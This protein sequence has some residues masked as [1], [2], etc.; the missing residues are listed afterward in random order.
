MALDLGE[1][2]AKMRV[3]R[4]GLASG[5]DAGRWEIKAAANSISDDVEDGLGK[6]GERGSNRMV[7]AITGGIGSLGPAMMPMLMT[8]GAAGG[9][10]LATALVASLVLAVPI[11]LAGGVLAAG[12]MAAAKD[13]AVG[14]AFAPLKTQ[15][16]AALAK[17][18]EPFKGPLIRAATT[19]SNAL[20]QITP[21]LTQMGTAVA[22]LVDQLA[23]MLAQMAVSIMPGLVK[24]VQA[25]VP[26]LA[27]LIRMLP[28]LGAAIGSV[29]SGIAAAVPWALRF[30]GAV[31]MIGAWIGSKLIPPLKSLAGTWLQAARAA[32]G[33]V[34]SA[35]QSNRPQ[36]Q[37][38][39]HWVS[40]IVSWV[41]AHLV[42]VLKSQ[43]VGSLRAAG[44][45]ISI[46]IR[47]I[48]LFVTAIQK[49]VGATKTTVNA[50]KS[51]VSGI[52]SFWA[53]LPGQIMS[54]LNSLP[55]KMYS[56]GVSM[57][58][59]LANGMASM[60]SAAVDRVRS[61]V[62]EISSLIPGSPVKKGPLRALNNGRAG[63]NII[64][65]LMGG[66]DD[67]AGNLQ[68]AFSRALG[69]PGGVA[70]GVGANRAGLGA[71][72]GA[73][74]ALVRLSFEGGSD[75]WM[76]A[77]RKSVRVV[78]QGDSQAALGTNSVPVAAMG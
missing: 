3:D 51:G 59:S 65:M 36:L 2:V 76:L 71:Q 43:M 45:A 60:A 75:P 46:T 16:T 8:V 39:V 72:R 6:S 18:A 32:I 24:A 1:L 23:P 27:G 56:A 37:T 67:E 9:G 78:G 34:T 44:L 15:A 69:L 58:R 4:S 52:R 19:F 74:A 61:I 41:A 53:A 13:P 28:N 64:R 54:Y 49:I 21:Y 70:A 17:F 29:L 12:I 25:G 7:Q 5:L 48:S 66:V 40:V 30:L 55:G 62:G 57:I 77:L 47:A 10:V 42:P 22:P 20:A 14:A 63:R 35:F 11:A 31:G 73:Q 26:L 38:F 50:V 33:Q 68:R